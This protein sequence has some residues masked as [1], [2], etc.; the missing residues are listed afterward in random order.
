MNSLIHAF[1][2]HPKGQMVIDVHKGKEE[3][4][5]ILHY[6]DDGKGIPKEILRSIFEPFF[7]TNRQGGGSGLGLHIV[8]NLVTRK[9]NGT[10]R[11]DSIVDQGTTFTM[12]IPIT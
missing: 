9:L 8:Y 4:E 11:C 6:A 3:R 1:Q 12:K 2:D 5:L 7:T 10:I